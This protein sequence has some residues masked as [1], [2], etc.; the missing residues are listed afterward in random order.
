MRRTFADL[1]LCPDVAD[2]ERVLR[3]VNKASELG[4]RLAAV[5]LSLNFAEANIKSLLAVCREVKIDLATRVDLK[6]KT[7][8]ELLKALRRFRRRFEIVAVMCESKDVARQAAKDRRVDLLNF[9][10]LDFRR[11]FFDLAEAELASNGLAALEID[12]K[13]LLTLEGSSRIRLL[14]SLRR[15]TAIAKAFGVP[16]VISS[17]VADELLMRKPLEQAALANLFDLEPA[18]ALEAV[19]AKALS[20]VKRN[21]EKL[22]PKF[23]APGIRVVRRGKDC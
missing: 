17:G 16:I 4:Y 7:S 11:R 1:H 14:S 23:I 21:R 22:S 10:S 2:A 8:Q 3:V 12:M 5:T 20:I 19:S 15:E 9:S 13:P 18:V 6:P